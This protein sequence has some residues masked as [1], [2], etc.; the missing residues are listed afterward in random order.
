MSTNQIPDSCDVRKMVLRYEVGDPDGDT[1]HD[2]HPVNVTEAQQE[3][4]EAI[5]G[6]EQAQW[7]L[8][9]VMSLLRR[10]D[11]D[12]FSMESH[13]DGEQYAAMDWRFVS[14]IKEALK[15]TS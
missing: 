1:G 9:R 12:I 11:K 2:V 8:E 14:Q 7:E 5:C 3:F 15:L 6:V 4:D 13:E 10:M